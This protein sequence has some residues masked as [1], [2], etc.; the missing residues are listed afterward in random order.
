MTIAR[1]Q[2]GDIPLL[3][4]CFKSTY[5]SNPRLQEH[6]F[7]AW[8]YKNTPF[9]H[10]DEYT[11]LIH[12]EEGEIRSFI[13][14]VPLE[15]RAEGKV[16]SGCY[17]QNWHSHS[18]DGSALELLGKASAG[19]DYRFMAGITRD[20]GRIYQALRIPVLP[21]IPRWVGFLDAAR[22]YEVLG[23]IESNNR[24]LLDS[25][26]Q[27]LRSLGPSTLTAHVQRFDDQE[28]LLPVH[29]TTGHIRRT[30]RYLNWRYLD[31]PRHDYRVLRGDGHQFAVYRVEPIMGSTASVVRLLEWNA[32]EGWAKKAMAT[33]LQ[34]G[35]QHQAI[36][37][38]FSCTSTHVGEGLCPMGFI[39]EA[40]FGSL[41]HLFRPLYRSEGI[42]LALDAP[43]HFRP[44]TINFDDWYITKGDSDMDRV[45]L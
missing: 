20:A 6:D 38:D 19:F 40:A 11:L 16:C 43:P 30:G 25:S 21:K 22:A 3:F 32:T 35:R 17:I 5:P 26:E 45:K 2:E 18:R 36:M 9:T 12:W 4:E 27:G 31:I 14:Y 37:I 34:D 24:H 8:Q 10:E 1:C 15:I 13:G 23:C 44:R 29:A 41:P 39:N 7:F 28:E 42:G 33:I